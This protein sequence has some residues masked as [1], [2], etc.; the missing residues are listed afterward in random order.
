MPNITS[1]HKDLF[2]APDTEDKLNLFH[3]LLNANELNV[4]LSL[5]LLK[6]IHGELGNAKH[7][8]HSIYKR[9][10]ASIETLRYRMLDTLQLV[11]AAWKNEQAKGSTPPDWF[12]NEPKG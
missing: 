9:Y 10:A 2:R 11:V 1:N 5:A 6:I 7:P 3:S 4:T 12:P 8:N